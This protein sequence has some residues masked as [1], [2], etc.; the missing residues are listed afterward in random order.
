MLTGIMPFDDSDV[1]KM[2]RVQMSRGLKYPSNK[3]DPQ[4][5]DLISKML[6]PEVVNRPSISRVLKFPWLT[7]ETSF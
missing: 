7:L 4:A 2:V 1:N 6:D 3:I 5:K